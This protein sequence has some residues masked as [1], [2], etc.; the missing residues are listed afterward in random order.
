MAKTKIKN[1]KNEIKRLMDDGESFLEQS[2]TRLRESQLDAEKVLA[3]LSDT[4]ERLTA[5]IAQAGAEFD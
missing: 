3:R 5:Q 4:E 1:L 2:E